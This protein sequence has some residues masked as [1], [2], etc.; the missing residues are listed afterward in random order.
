[1]S[2]CS[3]GSKGNEAHSFQFVLVV[4]AA[5]TCDRKCGSDHL[6]TC[7][8]AQSDSRLL[9]LVLGLGSNPANNITHCSGKLMSVC[10]YLEF[11]YEET[12]KEQ[13]SPKMRAEDRRLSTSEGLGVVG[14]W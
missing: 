1:M 13:H 2:P 5:Q 14:I 8:R 3:A 4:I 7:C 6:D 12:S 11:S 10:C 9:H